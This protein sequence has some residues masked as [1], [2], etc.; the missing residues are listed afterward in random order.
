MIVT[1]DGLTKSYGKVQA[2]KSLSF[3]VREGTL[4]AFLGANGA[5]K[6]TT[7]RCLATLLAPDS[8]HATVA[9]HVLGAADQEIR[10]AIGL[11]SQAS[12]LDPLLSAEECLRHRAQMHGMG[13]AE[14]AAR[15]REVVHE[16]GASDYADRRCGR[17]SGGQRRRVDIARALL[18]RPRLLFLDEPT[19]GLDPAS[20]EQ[21]WGLVQGLRRE[22][23]T[24]VFLTTHYLEETEQADDVV[25]IDHGE[26]LARGT[27]AELRERHS[28]HMLTVGPAPGCGG[29]VAQ[30]GAGGAV[31]G[32]VGAGVDDGGIPG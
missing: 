20:R 10:R 26:T 5:G 22:E 13:R 21:I 18:H 16:V 9:G 24:T 7:I 8:G 1:T 2:V 11:V 14:A 30:A 6:S 17:L 28:A 19:A 4:F 12:M 15:A 31:G 3:E 29:E 25:I 23:G 27:P 32:G